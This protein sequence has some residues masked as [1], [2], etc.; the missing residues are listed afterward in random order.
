MECLFCKGE[1]V[2]ATAPFD[3]A[4]IGYHIHF[5]KVRAWVCSQCGE[6]YFEE[7]EVKKIQETV[8][9]LDRQL[10]GWQTDSS[11]AGNV[12]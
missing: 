7:Q 11:T 10:L 2:I 5:D 4:K 6:P 3:F 12:A 1:M 9:L 8:S